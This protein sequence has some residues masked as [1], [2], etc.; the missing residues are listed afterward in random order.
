[1]RGGT[2]FHLI[3]RGYGRGRHRRRRHLHAGW[4]PR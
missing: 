4:R 1:V 2:A 3:D